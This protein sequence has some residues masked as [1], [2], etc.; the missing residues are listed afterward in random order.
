M[1]LSFV[2]LIAAGCGGGLNTAPVTGVITLDDE[3]LPNAS[4]TFTPN[5]GDD[6][7]PT[8]NGRTDADGHYTLTVT[9]SGEEGAVI[10]NHFVT[11]A[12]IGEEKTGEDADVIDPTADDG[13]PD[14][15]FSFD[16]KPGQ[17]EANFD[18]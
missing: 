1:A 16:V 3:P 4:V 11:I 14:H 9:V 18:L 17:N 13:L 5:T 10:G 7:A 2:L 15:N 12:L 8:S 6:T